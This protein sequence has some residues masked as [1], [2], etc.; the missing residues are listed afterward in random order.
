MKK[1]TQQK[2]ATTA[3][4]SK[5]V[6]HK[7]T[8][9]ATASAASLAPLRLGE[10][11]AG[12]GGRYMGH[13]FADDGRECLLVLHVT[14]FDDVKYSDA[15]KR[16]KAATADG[17][18]DFS[19]PSRREARLLYINGAKWLAGLLWTSEPCAD[20]SSYAWYQSFGYG[21]QYGSHK[22]DKLR[23]CAVRRVYLPI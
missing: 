22:D 4:S 6:V 19:A 21:Y 7:P 12:Q 20:G 9:S 5:T 3:K 16:A 8:P 1:A 23:G 17:H 15:I 18:K 13:M 2:A 10:I 11:W 14:V